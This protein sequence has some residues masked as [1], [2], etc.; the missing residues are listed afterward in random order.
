MEVGLERMGRCQVGKAKPIH[1]AAAAAPV[2]SD[3]T[4]PPP[5]PAPRRLG[6]ADLRAAAQQRR[7][8]AAS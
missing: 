4:P 7:G 1:A 3:P 2:V 8:V 6:L 5:S